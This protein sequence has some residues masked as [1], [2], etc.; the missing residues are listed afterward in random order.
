MKQLLINA[1]SRRQIKPS[2]QVIDFVSDNIDRSFDA[3]LNAVKMV[4]I[5]IQESGKNI[6]VAEVK[7][8]GIIKKLGG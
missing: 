7:K 5:Y 8:I 1:F 4:E 2:R 3:V 6:T